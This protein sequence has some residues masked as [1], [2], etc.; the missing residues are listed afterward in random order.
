MVYLCIF[1]ALL[2]LAVKG[3]CGKKISVYVGGTGDS[4]LFN[5]ARMIFCII[6][7]VAVVFM[8]GAGG[9]LYV[10]MRMLCICLLAG[11]ANTAFLVGWLLAVQRNAMVTV[12]VTL[13]LGSLIPAVLCAMLFGEAMSWQKMIGFALILAAA[14]IL[15]GYNKSAGVKASP[16]GVLFLLLAAAGDGITGFCQQL[17]KQYY[18][19]SGDLTHGVFYSNSVYQ[20]YTFVFAALI[21]LAVF[22]CYSLYKY[23]K[24]PAEEQGGNEGNE[25]NEKNQKRKQAKQFLLRTAVLPLRRPL[26]HIVVMAVCLFAASYFQTVATGVYGMSSQILYPVIKGGCL[27]TVNITAML[28][29]GEKPTRRSILGSLVALGG[30]V[31]MNVL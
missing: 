4:F 1:I 11:A 17:Y 26:P 12:D 18:T 10:E 15:A 13:T 28:F 3:Y 2:C 6:I 27:I 16:R 29:F 7:G 19:E 9:E 30:I 20:F 23:I 31:A 25:K 14:L 5:L 8:E 22:V 24:S 21:L